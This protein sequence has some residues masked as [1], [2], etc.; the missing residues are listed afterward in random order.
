VR[1]VSAGFLAAVRGSH[2]AKFRARVVETFQTGT[3]PDGVELSIN[4]GNVQIDGTA[5]IRSTLDLTVDGT[6][7]WPVRGGRNLLAPYGNEIFVERGVFLGGGSTEWVSLGYFRIEAPS[8]NLL[9]DGPIR[10]T[11]SDRM[12]GIKDARPLIPRQYLASDTY[13]AVVADVVTEVYPGATIVWDSGDTDTLGRDQVL[14]QDRYKFLH[15]L[16]TSLGKTVYWNHRG[17]LSIQDVPNPATPVFEVNAGA[18]GVLVQGATTRQLSRENVYN[19]VVASGEAADEQP[20]VFGI[21]VDNDPTS[22]T[23]Y[24]GRFGPVPMF[25]SSTFMTTD[26][27][28][29]AAAAGLLVKNTGLPYSIDFGIVPNPALEP[30]DPVLVTYSRRDGAEVHVLKS[31]TVP[32][33]ADGAMKATTR[34]QSVTIIGGGS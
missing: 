21:A 2:A 1:P 7:L 17:E 29:S 27:Q 8:Q 28:A 4:T 15:D 9:P 30:D 26:A 18:N 34:E 23:Y 31:V 19:A 12:A 13:G 33:T 22:P 32:L 6:R 11:G 16:I 14:D 25:F 3:N 10:I 24:F 5:D 20:P